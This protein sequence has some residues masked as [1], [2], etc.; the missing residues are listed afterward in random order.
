MRGGVGVAGGGI[1]LAE[2]AAIARRK[3]RVGS[4]DKVVLAFDVKLGKSKFDNGAVSVD[5]TFTE[6]LKEGYDSVVVEWLNDKE[7]VVYNY[8]QCKLIGRV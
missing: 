5:Y 2:T 3:S 1:Y 6:L 7:Y 4:S 8:D